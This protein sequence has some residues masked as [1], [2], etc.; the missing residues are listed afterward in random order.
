MKEELR[1]LKGEI[2]QKSD[3]KEPFWQLSVSTWLLI[4]GLVL[5]NIGCFV[6]PSLLDSILQ[7]LDVRLWP[8]WYFIPLAI[9]SIFAVKWGMIAWRYEDY[10]EYDREAASRFM[11]MS[12]SWTVFAGL[13]LLLNGINVLWRL[14]EPLK[15]WFGYGDFSIMGLIAFVAAVVVLI[16]LV[17]WTKEWLMT[18]WRP[19]Q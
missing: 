18:F 12:I 11:R 2:V 10:D 13:L 1:N 5:F 8:W 7:A 14:T 3:T 6:K 16:P 17:Y 4:A 19:D 9:L 15:R